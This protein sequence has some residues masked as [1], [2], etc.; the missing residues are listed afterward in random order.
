M[1]SFLIFWV[2]TTQFCLLQLGCMFRCLIRSLLFFSSLSSS[3]SYLIDRT[4][5]YLSLNLKDLL[6]GLHTCVL[7]DADE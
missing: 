3:T 4:E 5:S 2:N 1:I 7:G 6:H